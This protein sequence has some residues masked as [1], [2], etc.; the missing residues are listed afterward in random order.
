[1][2]P[3]RGQWSRLWFRCPGRNRGVHD[4]RP[5]GSTHSRPARARRSRA[6]GSVP[7]C[8]S[9]PSRPIPRQPPVSASPGGV[10]VHP[11]PNAT[12]LGSIPCE[13]DDGVLGRSALDLGVDLVTVQGD[14]IDQRPGQAGGDRIGALLLHRRS[15]TRCGVRMPK[16]ASK[17]AP[18][19][20]RRPSRSERRRSMGGVAV[21]RHRRARPTRHPWPG[22][23]LS[24]PLRRPVPGRRQRARRRCSQ[25]SGRARRRHR[26]PPRNRSSVALHV[27]G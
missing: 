24:Q 3:P 8:R 16:S 23:R 7:R 25:G 22:A 14:R 6:C 9:G 5:S 13:L 12:A 18:S 4:P 19:A 21:T 11:C 10:A 1:M 17:T 27:H 2:L 20:S 26:P 15:R